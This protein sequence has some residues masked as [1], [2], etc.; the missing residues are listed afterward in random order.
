MASFSA[1][2]VAGRSSAA[3]TAGAPPDRSASATLV[4]RDTAAQNTVSIQKTF[5]K[6]I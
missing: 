1:L 4:G 6:L 2:V 5:S 3:D